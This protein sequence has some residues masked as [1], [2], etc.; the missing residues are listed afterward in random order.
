MSHYKGTRFEPTRIFVESYNNARFGRNLLQQP[1]SKLGKYWGFTSVNWLAVVLNSTSH[2]DLLL[3]VQ[4]SCYHQLRLVVKI[5][6][7]TRS[8][9]PRWLAEFLN[10]EQYGVLYIEKV[11]KVS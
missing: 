10:H 11:Q 2:G 5:P 9:H 7:F 6:S 8:I 4:K 3:M 1:W